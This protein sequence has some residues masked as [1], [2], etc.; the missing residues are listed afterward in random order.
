MTPDAHVTSLREI[1]ILYGCLSTD[2]ECESLLRK[3]A[4]RCGILQM[5]DAEL[6][7]V[8]LRATEAMAKGLQDIKASDI[9]AYLFGAVRL[10]EKNQEETINKKGEYIEARDA[11]VAYIR[12]LEERGT[13]LL[14]KIKRLGGDVSQFPEIPR[15][16]Q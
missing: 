14:N 7:K 4:A 15:P 11:H 12:A 5:G 6:E 3:L 8:K 13:A 2:P 9:Y 1:T 16:Q 10:A